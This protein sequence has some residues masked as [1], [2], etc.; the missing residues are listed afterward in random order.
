[1]AEVSFLPSTNTGKEPLLAGNVVPCIQK[2]RNSSTSNSRRGGR[3]PIMDYRGGS[4]KGDPSENHFVLW[5]RLPHCCRSEEAWSDGATEQGST[6]I[7]TDDIY[8]KSHSFSFLAKCKGLWSRKDQ[9]NKALFLIF[10]NFWTPQCNA[11]LCS[12]RLFGSTGGIE[13]R[14]FSFLMFL[15]LWNVST[16]FKFS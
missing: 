5:C 16:S 4:A 3:G 6:L 14:I 2:F 15:I 12:A 11:L 10:T 1:M 8:I 7:G 9:M 13:V